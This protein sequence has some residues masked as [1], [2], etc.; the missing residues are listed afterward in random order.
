MNLY[1]DTCKFVREKLIISFHIIIV[2][3][4]F[5]NSLIYTKNK[6]VSS[7]NQYENI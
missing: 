6:T 2:A 4:L 5:R 3:V 1:T 7:F